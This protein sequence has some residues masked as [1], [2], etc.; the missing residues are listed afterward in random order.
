MINVFVS[1]PYLELKAPYEK[2]IKQFSDSDVHF[3]VRHIIDI[4]DALEKAIEGFDIVIARGITA[5]VVANRCPSKHIIEIELTGYDV[6]QAILT[7]KEN[8]NP[9]EI[10]I[11]YAETF[12][13]DVNR[14]YELTGIKVVVKKVTNEAD[15]EK[16]ILEALDSGI[17]TFICGRTG[18]TF[19]DING[20]NYVA[21][22]TGKE[23]IERSVID[24]VKAA[25][26][27]EYER[28]KSILIRQLLDNNFDGEIALDADGNV[29]EENRMAR[30]LLGDG[31]EN[32]P[33]WK[34]ALKSRSEFEKIKMVNNMPCL[35][36]F[37]PI[38][39]L[40]KPI[41]VNIVI[42]NS[43][44]LRESDSKIRRELK[45]RGLVAR[46]VFSD[47]VGESNIIKNAVDKAR[48][49]SLVES[50]VLI[51]GETGTGKE[52]FAHSMHNSSPRSHEPFVAVNC[53]ALPGDLLESEL[54]G[55]VEGA[56]SG[57]VRGG[58]AGLFEI[59]HGGTIFLDEIGEIPLDVQSKL[60]RVLQE[61]E[62]RRIGDTRVRHIDVRIIA[63]TNVDIKKKVR[64]G[65]FRSDLYYRLSVLDLHLAPLRERGNDIL[66]LADGFLSKYAAREG[67]NK[68]KLSKD[69][70]AILFSYTWPG[71]IRELRNVCEKIIVLF[72]KPTITEKDIK[73][74]VSVEDDAVSPLDSFSVEALV[75]SGLVNRSALAKELGISRTTLWRKLKDSDARQK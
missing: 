41:G 51:T 53:A 64:D 45:D 24:A 60:L 16:A 26:T 48:R 25:K 70:E 3:E 30:K 37:I 33:E 73:S 17:N 56:F 7:C 55:Y 63:A 21:I 32:I 28:S 8:Y 15:T 54:F 13:C 61:K 11:I 40:D 31:L 71:N 10:A 23:A 12:R 5:L 44:N 68:P 9:E 34:D 27:I 58:K 72:D 1:L 75:A 35:F 38:F 20:L 2:C 39:R 52:L 67:R 4:H 49:F 36:R 22:E 65:L 46:Y 47:I 19:C 69:A 59:A 29:I 50:S 74:I 66:L 43:E 18:A 62:I 42:Q 14:I 57:A 6:F